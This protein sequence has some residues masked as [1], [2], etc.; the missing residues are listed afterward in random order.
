[1]PALVPAFFCLHISPTGSGCTELAVVSRILGP[2]ALSSS[3]AEYSTQLEVLVSATHNTTSVLLTARFFATVLLELLEGQPLLQ[4]LERHL[5]ILHR[6]PHRL[7]PNTLR[8]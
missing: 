6:M 2:L 5:N 3:Q 7:Y 4:M 8:Q 1:M